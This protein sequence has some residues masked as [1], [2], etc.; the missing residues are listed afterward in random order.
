MYVDLKDAYFA[1]PFNAQDRKHLRFGW[2]DKV[3]ASI[4][5]FWA[6]MYSLGTNSSP[7]H[8][9]D[10]LHW[11]YVW[12]DEVRDSTEGPHCG[13]PLPPRESRVVINFPKSLL[14]PRRMVDFLS[15]LMNS[16]I[17]ELK[18]PGDKMK[19]IQ[20]EAKK[21]LSTRQITALE[22]SSTLGKMNA[23]TKAISIATLLL[24]VANGAST[25]LEQIVSKLQYSNSF[26][27]RLFAWS[28][29]PHLSISG[30]HLHIWNYSD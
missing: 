23:A 24:T 28:H 11:W 17:M 14:Q 3:I 27:Q 16:T 30:A 13:D 2:R 15:F 9:T 6:V 25:S 4:A 21:L 12:H 1:V 26:V 29:K 5:Y 8:K 20:G 10:Y 22:L 7:E 19:S 18:L